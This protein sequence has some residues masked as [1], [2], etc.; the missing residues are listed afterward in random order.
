M[1]NLGRKFKQ[2]IPAYAGMTKTIAPQIFRLT[3]CM[4][5]HPRS[6]QLDWGSNPGAI[7]FQAHNLLLYIISSVK[8]VLNCRIFYFA[9]NTH[10]SN[11]NCSL[12]IVNL[13]LV[14]E[15]ILMIIRNCHSVVSKMKKTAH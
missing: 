7:E 15:I 11:Y 5:R 13:T 2:W 12:F 6:P 10:T 14:Y 9:A 8:S 3:H 1:T 4:P